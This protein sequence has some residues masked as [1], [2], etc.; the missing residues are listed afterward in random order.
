MTDITIGADISKH[1]IDLHWLPDGKRLR[2]T[3]DRKGF[4]SILTWMSGEAVARIAYE[5]TGA[6]HK[7]F[8]RFML[9]HGVALSK[10][11]PRLA[12]RF[13]EATGSL[14]KTDQADA[15]MLARYGLLLTPRLLRKETVELN[16]LKELH[17]ARLAL[18]KDR[19]ATKNRQKNLTL[20]LLKRH[21]A[22][23]LKQIEAQL[24]QVDQAIMAIIAG[25]ETLKTRFDIIVSIPGLSTITAFALLIEM[26]ELGELEDKAAAAL[27]GLAPRNR[28]SGGWTGR[29]CI[30]GGR[31]IVRRAL[32]MPAI[33]AIR[34]NPDLKAKYESLIKAG[35]PP[36]V[37]ITALM[38]KLV[39]LT[40]TLLRQN[41]K[42]KPKPA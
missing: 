18:I 19:T 22:V 11:N 20:P 2:V 3:N 31:A 1:H 10:V 23:R 30:A 21:N 41:R 24:T 25:D 26:P 15:E 7:T 32:Y 29:A 13:A 36:K 17:V 8:E 38:R 33:V 6:Y 34:F 42:W 39:V 27:S 4:A 14:I 35:K 37:A 5:P 16:D 40:N 9:T 12:R 28:Q